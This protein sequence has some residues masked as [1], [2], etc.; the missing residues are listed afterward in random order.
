[1]LLNIF[2]R[3][4]WQKYKCPGVSQLPR[5]VFSIR[6]FPFTTLVSPAAVSLLFYTDCEMQQDRAD[7]VRNN[8]LSLIASQPHLSQATDQ[9]ALGE[10]LTGLLVCIDCGRCEKRTRKRTIGL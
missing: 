8:L 10:R 4:E 1:M 5:L 7:S 9:V 3:P 2:P 6:H